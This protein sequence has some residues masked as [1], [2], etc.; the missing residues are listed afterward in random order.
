MSLYVTKG[1]DA[2]FELCYVPPHSPG[3]HAVRRSLCPADWIS[4]LESVY[5]AARA[6]LH[7][8]GDGVN[9]LAFCWLRL[10]CSA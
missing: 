8:I 4:M 10:C 2:S 9:S 5:R 3:I 6:P 7:A 1:I